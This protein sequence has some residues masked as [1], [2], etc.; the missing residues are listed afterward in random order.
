MH[1][2]DCGGA[3]RSA[4]FELN[5]I[6]N[7][8]CFVYETMLVSTKV[9]SVDRSQFIVHTDGRTDPGLGRSVFPDGQPLKY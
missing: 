2:L 1:C 7:N 4:F 3:K 9:S 6:S 5:V 8:V